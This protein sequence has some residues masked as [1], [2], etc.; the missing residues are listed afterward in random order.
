[1][2]LLGIFRSL[3]SAIPIIISFM[4]IVWYFKDLIKNIKELKKSKQAYKNCEALII[5]EYP[6]STKEEIEET[7]ETCRFDYTS[8]LGL[9][10]IFSIIT[11]LATIFFINSIIELIINIKRSLYL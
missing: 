2:F 3:I 11:I 6:K 9:F 7:K 4:W 8:N 5:S 10:I 1:M